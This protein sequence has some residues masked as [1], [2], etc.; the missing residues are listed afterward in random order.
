L[1]RGDSGVGKTVIAAQ[2]A[3]ANEASFTKIISSDRFL[4]LN[5]GQTMN[6]IVR[7]FEDA[8]RCTKSLIV[9]DDLLR[10]ID[11]IPLGSK[12]N[13]SILNLII[14]LIKKVV[15]PSKKQIIIATVSNQ[16]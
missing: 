11:F 2:C 12:Y 4:G 14:N 1:I 10:L 9:L 15:S 7:I 13:S 3:L 6:E 5:E 8:E 16:K